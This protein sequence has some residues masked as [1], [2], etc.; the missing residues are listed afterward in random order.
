MVCFVTR[1]AW[2]IV[3]D[4]GVWSGAAQIV[5]QVLDTARKTHVAQERQMQ[6]KYRQKLWLIFNVSLVQSL[7]LILETDIQHLLQPTI[8]MLM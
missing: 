4:K 7:Y 8:C 2:K 6:G 5:V 1:P 3:F